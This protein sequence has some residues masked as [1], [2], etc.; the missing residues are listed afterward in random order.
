MDK[1]LK[2]RIALELKSNRLWRAKELLS[3]AIKNYD[4]DEELYFE[5]ARLLYR[6]G[7]YMES[8]KYFLLTNT[9][10]KEYLDAIE[11]FLSRYNYNFF[12]YLP[13]KFKKLDPKYYPTNIKNTLDKKELDYIYKKYNLNKN[14]NEDYTS[15][16]DMY[17]AYIIF[18]LVLFLLF[19]GCLKLIE[20]IITIF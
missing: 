5:Y 13:R 14:S 3:S 7:D 6:L 1:K 2:E 4:Y 18:A 11:L 10:K 17:I 19:L 16:K 8:G 12:G 20:L 9:K 15:K